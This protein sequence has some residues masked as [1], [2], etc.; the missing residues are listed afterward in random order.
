VRRRTQRR[1]RAAILAGG[2]GSRLDGRKPLADLR[3]R[4]LIGYP[5]SAAEAAGLDPFVVAKPGSPLPGLDCEVVREPARPSHPLVGALAALRAA[6]GPVLLLGCD[7]PFLTP[8][9]LAWLAGLEPPAVAVVEGTLQP[10]LGLYGES[11]EPS[12]TEALVD[13]AP[14]REAVDRLEPRRLGDEELERFGDPARLTF[15]VD[16]P[17]DLALA[18]RLLQG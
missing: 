11:A 5:L 10:L 1:R 17:G 14:F 13:E 6:N 9:L 16:T 2:R 15:S 12:F 8:E 7:M 4:P 18:A 3:G